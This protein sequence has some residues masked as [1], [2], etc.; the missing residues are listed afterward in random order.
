MG[1]DLQ[2]SYVA[3]DGQVEQTGGLFGR[4]FRNV[5]GGDVDEDGRCGVDVV[6]VDRAAA[7]RG[8]G[9]GGLI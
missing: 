8:L 2:L 7:T 4:R 9:H 3:G 6:R 1:I 5:R